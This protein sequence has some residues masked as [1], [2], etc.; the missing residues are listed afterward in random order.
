MESILDIIK[1]RAS[2]RSYQDKPLPKETVDAILEAARY[3]PSARDL[4][5]LEYR[6]ITSRGLIARL[7]EA[8]AA[9]V[10]REGLPLKGPPGRK[11]DFFYSAPLL[12]LV[13]GPKDNHWSA[14][15][16]AL[17]VQNIM[18]YA[19]SVGLGSC[20]IGMAR[21]IQRDEALLRE[22]HIPA[23]KDIVAAVICGYPA[24][25]PRAKEKRLKAEF[26]E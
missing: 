10:S 4:Q 2:I 8:I 26:F 25:K 5:E 18:L 20:F 15:D 12:V 6:V 16:A 21:F 11:P 22:L 23:D 9:A 3:A 17:A 19:T 24:E 13:T 1:K 7:S 14:T